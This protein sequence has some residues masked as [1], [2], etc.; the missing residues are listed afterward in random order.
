[1]P[2]EFLAVGGGVGSQ[3]AAEESQRLYHLGMRELLHLRLDVGEPHAR[4]LNALE[5]ACKSAFTRGSAPSMTISSVT[6]ASALHLYFADRS[7]ASRAALRSRQRVRR[8]EMLRAGVFLR[9]LV[10]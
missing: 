8:I 10:G 6:A 4:K 3:P 1:M 2:C 5:R 9:L 7:P